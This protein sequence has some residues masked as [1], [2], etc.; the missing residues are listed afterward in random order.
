M[1]SLV[2]SCHLHLVT[3]SILSGKP[4]TPLPLISTQSGRLCKP[5]QPIS[6]SLIHISLTLYSS[7]QTPSLCRNTLR[8]CKPPLTHFVKPRHQCPTS[9]NIPQD[10]LYPSAT[11]VNYPHLIC[12]SHSF[13]FKKRSRSLLTYL[14]LIASLLPTRDLPSCLNGI[15][16]PFSLLDAR[17][18]RVRSC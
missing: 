9:C 10:I 8:L 7:N 14:P 6:D 1:M 3:P 16:A 2:I 5:P 18:L 13:T 17:R 4:P 11:C 15:H 12:L